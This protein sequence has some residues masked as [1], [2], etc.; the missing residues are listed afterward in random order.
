MKKVKRII[1]YLLLVFLI[2]PQSAC[3]DENKESKQINK[4]Q[5]HKVIGFSQLGAESDWRIANSE[6]VRN[7]FSRENG[8]ELLFD[9]GQQKQ[10]KQIMALRKFIQQEVD[11]IILAPV[12]ET[13]W[14][15]VLMEARDAGIPVIVVDRRVDVKDDDYLAWIGS[16]FYREGEVACEWLKSFTEKKGIAPE[17]IHIADIQGTIGATAQ[18]GRTESLKKACTENGWDLRALEPADYTEAK[19]YEVVSRLIRE[20]EDINVLYCEN[21]NEALGAILAVEE[22]G[23]KV[24]TDIEN[25]EIMIIS[26][27]AARAGLKKVLEGKIALDVECNP[28]QGPEIERIISDYS[29]GNPVEKNTYVK[30][31]IFAGDDTVK[32]IKI[33]NESCPITVVTDEVLSKR[34][35]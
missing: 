35:Y 7:T 13:G 27:D 17:D 21:D 2:I 31:Q 14:D 18:I 28:L 16:D 32:E 26:F 29:A 5:P 24:G 6:S 1:V 10:D 8:Y 33:E 4:K 9:D 12:T 20:N 22:Q 25:G 23:R 11:Y 19:G 34:E 30:E 3:G 15:S